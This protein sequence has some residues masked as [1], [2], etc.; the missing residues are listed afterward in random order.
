[1][2]RIALKIILHFW[3]LPLWIRRVCAPILRI[4]ILA[5][6]QILDK[7]FKTN[8][9]K[10]CKVFGEA[11]T[12]RIKKDIVDSF[13]L[14]GISPHEYFLF[15]FKERSR[16]ERDSFLSDAYRIQLLKKVIGLDLFKNELINK[17]G[18]YCKQKEYFHR[19]VMKVGKQTKVSEFI[20]FVQKEKTVFVKENAGS[21][22]HNARKIK[23]QD[24]QK[25]KSIFSELVSDESEWIVEGYIEQDKRMACW[26]E[27]SVNTIRIPSFLFDNDTMILVPF[28]RTGRY[29]A[30]V[31]NAG[32]GGIFASIDEKTGTI[33][34]D[35]ADE[36]GN[37]YQ[38]HPDS[39]IK[40]KGWQVP[41]WDSLLTM[42]KE[43]HRKMKQHK[44]LAYDFALTPKGWV[45]VE[46]NWGQYVCQQTSTQKGYKE[47]FVKLLLNK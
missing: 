40:Y 46:G 22:G 3:Q 28:I 4:V 25:L 10:Q 19:T 7:D 30:E 5:A 24:G 35:G 8:I 17:Y 12:N 32:A 44:Y 26:N 14:Y 16:K 27:S 34:S 2:K 23:E 45:M 41:A 39:N 47:Q 21:F 31:D 36:S 43:A 9:S 15:K 38:C 1:M 18:F 29:G 42:S 11:C 33:I 20:D 6:P 37:F 13:V